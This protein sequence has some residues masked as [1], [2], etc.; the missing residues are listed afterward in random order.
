[1]RVRGLGYLRLNVTDLDAWRPFLTG[2]VGLAEVDGPDPGEGRA[3]FRMDERQWRVCLSSADADGLGSLGLELG[4]DLELDEAVARVRATGTDVVVDDG[5]AAVRGVNGLARFIDP[6]GFEVEL[7]FGG[8]TEF[9]PFASPAGVRAFKTD[10]VGMGHALLMVPDDDPQVAFYQQALGFRLTDLIQMGDGKSARFLR[11]TRRHHTLA[12]FDVMPMSG[13]HHFM[14]EVE[15][16]DDVG[17]AYDR[18]VDA[19]VP[20]TNNLGRHTNDRMFSFYARTPSGFDMEVG[21]GGVEVDDETW[22]VTEFQGKGDLWGH[23]G[24]MMDE[25]EAAR[26]DS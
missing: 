23:R 14:V 11:T 9:V 5:L 24:S 16:L 15:D 12:F 21:W 20:I 2:V 4:S 13:L 3:F 8:K 7:Y 10:Q 6:S 1:M 17:L 18:A 22:T 19:K 26:T 25:I